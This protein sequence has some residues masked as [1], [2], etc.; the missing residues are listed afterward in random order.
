ASAGFFST[1]EQTAHLIGNN[2]T[3]VRIS[4]DVSQ[5]GSGYAT[6]GAAI[7]IYL[8]GCTTH[9]AR[10]RETGLLALEAL[11]DTGIVTEVVKTAAQRA[12]P[13]QASGEGEFF[14]RGSSFFS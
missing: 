2:A 5:L 11:I 7:S 10:A 3:S 14:T 4:H 9:N 6:G 12:R 13:L 8:I 1:D